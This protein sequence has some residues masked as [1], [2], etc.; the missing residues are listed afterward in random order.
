MRTTKTLISL[1]TCAGWSETS[2]GAHVR[3]YVFS[4]YGSFCFMKFRCVKRKFTWLGRTG[5]GRVPAQSGLGISWSGH[6][7][8]TETFKCPCVRMVSTVV[9][10]RRQ[11][12][13][14]ESTPFTHAIKN[15]TI[16]MQPSSLY[17]LTLTRRCGDKIYSLCHKICLCYKCW[18]F[19]VIFLWYLLKPIW[20]CVYLIK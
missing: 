12:E 16:F 10:M 1:R 18:I 13:L 4:R 17:F 2:L 7:V 11:C 19:I 3:R 8:C 20:Y 9:G 6:L 15:A 5:S 14:I